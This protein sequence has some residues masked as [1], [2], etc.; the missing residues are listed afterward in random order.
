MSMS[1]NERDA[2][3]EYAR[4]AD[5]AVSRDLT[6]DNMRGIA[7]LMVIGIH[8]LPQPLDSGLAKAVDAALR[9][10]VPVFLFVSGYLS[11]RTM[12]I[13]VFKRIKAALVPYTIAFAAAYIYMAAHNPAMD[14]RPW[15]AAARYGLG[16]V[17][18]YYYVP[19]YLGC[20]LTLWA[21]FSL[22][23][24]LSDG[25]RS[26][27]VVALMLSILL[28]LVAG[29]YL[30]PLLAWLG[31]S[32]DLIE[33]ARLRNIPFW[34]SFMALGAIVA[35]TGAERLIEQNLILLTAAATLGYA[36]YAAVRIESVGDAAA[37]DSAAYFA[38][39]AP[40][41]V[42]LLLLAPSSR[43]LAYIGSGSYFI[44]LWHIFIVMLLRDH[45]SWQNPAFASIA[46]YIITAAAGLAG[47]VAVRST[48]PSRAVRWL[49]A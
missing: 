5:I 14:H 36:I 15:I 26:G 21:L 7:I 48:L 39:A 1:T 10:A 17:F 35:I 27:L 8:A 43:W 29:S 18:V 19:I 22:R 47:L 2:A 25:D 37:Y 4:H 44:Y 28:G 49:G 45:V 6:I 24:L 30:D 41:C 20:T 33:E 16:Y 23:D 11:G 40:L 9:P 3:L 12:R 13:P 42:A 32:N 34:F 38:Y 31:A 46:S